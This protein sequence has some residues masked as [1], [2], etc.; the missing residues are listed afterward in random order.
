MTIRDR[1]GAV[2]AWFDQW[3][4][5]IWWLDARTEELRSII[6]R[7]AM[8]LESLDK[9]EQKARENARCATED[10][11]TWKRSSIE[12]AIEIGRLQAEPDKLREQMR[13]DRGAQKRV[14]LEQEE[15]IRK[16][17]AVQP[18]ERRQL[19]AAISSLTAE[20][21]KWKA[22]AE[23]REHEINKLNREYAELRARIEEVVSKRVSEIR[24]RE[25]S[26][27]VL[28]Y[29]ILAKLENARKERNALRAKLAAIEGRNGPVWDHPE[30][31]KVARR[32]RDV[33]TRLEIASEMIRSK[34]DNG[35]RNKTRMCYQP[36]TV[37]GTSPSTA[38]I[39]MRGLELIAPSPDNAQSR[40][41]PVKG[42]T[43]GGFEFGPVE[44]FGVEPGFT[45]R[46]RR[47]GDKTDADAKR[48]QERA[49]LDTICGVKA[50]TPTI[51]L[52]EIGA[53]GHGC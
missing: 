41:D 43:I 21:D 6:A 30:Y 3:R 50:T 32:L 7:Q 24:M 13:I 9:A 46:I 53:T 44:E 16:L 10:A 37:Y 38:G 36:E 52:G 34:D 25:A 51:Q 49:T 18:E 40:I 26:T 35:A 47:W 2:L 22:L 5:S 48:E 42:G 28:D 39:K 14:F 27:R 11:R 19:G 33:R 4:P 45:T 17:S 15:T 12:R 8:D 29:R 20:R 31:R 23:S 1:F